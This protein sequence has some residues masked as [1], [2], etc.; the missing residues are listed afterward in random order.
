MGT[1]ALP[2]PLAQSCPAPMCL[3]TCVR[4][5]VCLSIVQLCPSHSPNKRVAI[6]ATVMQLAMYAYVMTTS[7]LFKLDNSLF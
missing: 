2:V 6:E 3:L 4:V 1:P 7:L 5:C